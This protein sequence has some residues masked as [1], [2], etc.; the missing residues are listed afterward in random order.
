MEKNLG[1]FGEIR[2]Y[3]EKEML[4]D[5]LHGRIRYSCTKHE[6]V[7]GRHIFEVFIDEKPVKRF[8]WETVNASFIK[9]GFSMDKTPIGIGDYYARF[10]PLIDEC[11]M[12]Y[13]NEYTDN[14]FC[15]A[16]DKYRNQEIQRSIVSKNPIV[17]MFAILDRRIVKRTLVKIKER[18]GMQPNWLKTF[19]NLRFEA[20][21][22]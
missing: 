6:S 17:R 5:S 22:I 16:L 4:A 11:P 21:D 10:W 8:S 15:D 13:R 2:N 14:E 20:E 12:E 1:S 9:K 3:L 19:Y 18:I 7:D